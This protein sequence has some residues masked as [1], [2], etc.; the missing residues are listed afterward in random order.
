MYINISEF[1]SNHNELIFSKNGTCDIKD[2]N[3]SD[4]VN[5]T[6][7]YEMLISK[8]NEELILNLDIDFEYTKSCDRCLVEVTNTDSVNYSAKLVNDNQNDNIDDDFDIVLMNQN[9]IDI[10]KLVQELVILSI[11]MKNLCE[12]ECKGI[13]PKC[14]KDL[15]KGSCDCESENLDLRF[16]VLKD[17]EIDEEV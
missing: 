12:D 7:D 16:S 6:A 3:S 13:C 14:G 15:N 17:F 2:D 10:C 8:V 4:P 1:I 11:P 5:G 9:T